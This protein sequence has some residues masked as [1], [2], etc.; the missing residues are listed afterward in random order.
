ME[1][2]R[3]EAARRLW[4]AVE[5]AAERGA[6]ALSNEEREGLERQMWETLLLFQDETFYTAKKLSFSYSVR[7]NEIFVTR[8]EKSITRASVDL[9]FWKAIELQAG[10]FFVD[11]PKKL[12]IFGASY[13]YP[14]F[15]RAGVIQNAFN[16]PKGKR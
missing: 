8:K 2:E 4:E 15:I 5:Q 13:L 14:L 9:A 6:G 7:G 1:T 11:G 16:E 3:D 12:K 10:G